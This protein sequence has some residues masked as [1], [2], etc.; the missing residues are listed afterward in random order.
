MPPPSH[1]RESL[2]TGPMQS[3]LSSQYYMLTFL[4][5]SHPQSYL[6]MLFRLWEGVNSYMYDERMLHFLAQVSEMHVDPSISDPARIAIIPDDARSDD[7]ERP[8]FDKE[9]L[10]RTGPWNGIF[11]DV[12]IFTDDEWNFIMCKCVA[13]M[14]KFFWEA[15][16]H[17]ESVWDLVF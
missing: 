6:P 5:L 14:G 15:S 4:P 1:E 17:F 10:K 13:S 7:E 16:L 9:D 2:L 12:G 11:R 3:V 8:Y